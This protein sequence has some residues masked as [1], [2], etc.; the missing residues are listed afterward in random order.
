MHTLLRAERHRPVRRASWDGKTLAATAIAK[1]LG[2]E[3]Y[4]VDLAQVVSKYIGETERNLG[5]VSDV[6]QQGE[7]M[8][9]FD[10]ADSLFGKRTEAKSN[11]LSSFLTPRSRRPRTSAWRRRQ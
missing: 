8:L 6:A 3:I 1:A 10:E 11:G 2:Q 9:L 7:V 4:R 5:V